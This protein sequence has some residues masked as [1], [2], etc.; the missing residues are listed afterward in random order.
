MEEM[1]DAATTAEVL[2]MQD[3]LGAALTCIHE[4]KPIMLMGAALSGL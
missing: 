3:E 4:G 2:K 1:T